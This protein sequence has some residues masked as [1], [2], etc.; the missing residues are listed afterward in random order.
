MRSPTDCD[1]SNLAVALEAAER[2]RLRERDGDDVELE[3]G[4][5]EDALSSPKSLRKKAPERSVGIG[6]RIQK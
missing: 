1:E 6:E 4:G 2:E 3:T 5:T